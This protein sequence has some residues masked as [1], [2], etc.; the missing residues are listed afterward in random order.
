M[1]LDEEG[2]EQGSEAVAASIDVNLPKSKG[3]TKFMKKC[4][5]TNTCTYTQ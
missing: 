4:S 2:I 1:R 5:G 3:G